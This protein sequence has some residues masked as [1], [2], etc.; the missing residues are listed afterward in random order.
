MTIKTFSNLVLLS[1]GLII[2]KEDVAFWSPPNIESDLIAPPK[3]NKVL[4][5][6]LAL[7]NDFGW[8]KL[9]TGLLGAAVVFKSK[10]LL[11]FV[12]IGLLEPNRLVPV[13]FVVP[14]NILLRPVAP[15]VV[16]VVIGCVPK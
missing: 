15:T 11:A 3:L 9:K 2:G 12:V 8:K 10:K 5:A 4:A 1:N 7:M 13:E 14:P 16:N 6:T